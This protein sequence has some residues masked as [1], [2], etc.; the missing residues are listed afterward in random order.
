MVERGIMP[1]GTELTELN[2]MTPGTFAET[3]LVRP[4]AELSEEERRLFAR[5]AEVYAAFSEYTDVETGRIWR[6]PGSWTTR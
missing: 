2:P 3:D 6:S 4:W 5:M 1:E